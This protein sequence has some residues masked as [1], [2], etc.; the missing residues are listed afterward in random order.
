MTEQQALEEAMRRWGKMFPN[1]VF[2]SSEPVLMAGV[3]ECPGDGHRG[4]YFTGNTWEEVFRAHDQAEVPVLCWKLRAFDFFGRPIDRVVDHA[5]LAKLDWDDANDWTIR[6]KKTPLRTPLNSQSPI[7]PWRR[8][9]SS[10]SK[11][12]GQHRP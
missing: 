3:V 2:C 7:V 8:A 10:N 6:V 5:E 12:Q 11:Q 4:F 9:K 1:R